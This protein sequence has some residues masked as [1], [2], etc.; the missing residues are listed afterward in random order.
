MAQNQTNRVDEHRATHGPAP[1]GRP[2]INGDGDVLAVER[3]IN[4]LR[5]GRAVAVIS[6]DT[7][8]L[9]LSAETASADAIESLGRIAGVAPIAAAARGEFPLALTLAVS[10]RRAHA[11]AL[12]QE[13]PRDTIEQVQTDRGQVNARAVA[14][15]LPVGVSLSAVRTLAGIDDADAVTPT[16]IT[17]A[18]PAA[19]GLARVPTT[20]SLDAAVELSRYA[21]LLP[22]VITLSVV[23]EQLD[24]SVLRIDA[25][26]IERFRASRGTGLERIVNANVPLRDEEQCELV[27]FRD[28]GA[29]IEHL[30]IIV[31]DITGTG[32]VPVRV[33]SAC[34]TGDVL[35][36]LRC[37]CGDQLRNAMRRMSKRGGGVLLYLQQEGRGIGLANK[38]RAYSL[39]DQGLDTY[40]ADGHL[41]FDADDRSFTEAATMLRSLGVTKIALM[42]NNPHKV[43]ALAR[44]GIEVV[45]R[46]PL[47]GERNPYNE[48]YL[49]AKATRAGHHLHGKTEP[50]DQN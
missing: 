45:A 42:T 15:Q 20:E 39:Q 25:A 43:D 36:S 32:T 17:L 13:K 30:A 23:P 21:R 33:H 16:E 38:L 6:G 27:L 46:E 35:G 4:E 48:R 7:C 41:G 49:S 22:T 50:E 5:R 2:G 19:T 40:D 29:D 9:A 18:I 10:A 37:D 47:T 11:L 24:S 1:H 44:E 28:T 8:E 14:L 34:L 12:T 3:A 26:Q 31:G